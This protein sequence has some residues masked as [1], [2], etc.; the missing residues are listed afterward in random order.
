MDLRVIIKYRLV[1]P[2]THNLKPNTYYPPTT[3]GAQK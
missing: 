3:I 2:K 1:L